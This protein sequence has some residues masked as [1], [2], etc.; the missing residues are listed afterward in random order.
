MS[1]PK[2]IAIVGGGP[3]GLSLARLL[4]LGDKTHRYEVKVYE[5]DL[6]SQARIEGGSLD[7]HVGSGQ[8]FIDRAELRSAYEAVSRVDGGYY[9]MYTQELERV[10]HMAVPQHPEMDRYDLRTM[11]LDS[12]K[13]NTVEWNHHLLKIDVVGNKY[14]LWFK[15]NQ[16]SPVYCDA[17]IGADGAFS[18]IRTHIAPAMAKPTYS[19]VT[20]I[21]GE[22]LHPDT[23][24][25]K[26]LARLHRGNLFV[27]GSRGRHFGLQQKT[28]GSIIYY[29]SFKVP[30]HFM[31]EKYG[32]H[33]TEQEDQAAFRLA[34]LDIFEG[35]DPEILDVI[36]AT[37]RL[38]VRKAT[39]LMYRSTLE[40][41]WTDSGER[42]VP[43]ATLI[44]DAA[45][46]IPS[47]A[48]QGVNNAM[49]DAVELAEELL[50]DQD[51]AGA[52]SA[53]EQ[54]MLERCTR[55]AQ[56]TEVG[57]DAF[58]DEKDNIAMATKMFAKV[59]PVKLDD[60][61]KNLLA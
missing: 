8:V 34:M 11:L 55:A 36:E 30:E 52:F 51:C 59:G 13:P 21:Q 17:L 25:P 1:S 15:H 23:Q 37:D 40:D 29:A 27:L 48:G 3:G 18:K 24:C 49:M 5:R 46:V 43:L 42:K 35:F 12:L 41:R 26:M 61:W 2:Q 9:A 50:K 16:E 56:M 44:G 28:D 20:L 45:H 58:H 33:S 57:E 47:F 38:V 10:W 54:R 22:L 60:R 7:L 31:D 53:Y 32:I 14:A 6:N 39:G 19:G 4:Q